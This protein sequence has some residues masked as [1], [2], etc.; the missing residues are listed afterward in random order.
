MAEKKTEYEK[1][2]DSKLEE[3]KLK[4]ENDA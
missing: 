3:F 4:A 2:Y 1:D